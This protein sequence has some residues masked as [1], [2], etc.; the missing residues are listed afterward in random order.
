MMDDEG[1]QCGGIRF[2]HL[3]VGHRGY[4]FGGISYRQHSVSN[5]LQKCQHPYADKGSTTF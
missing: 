3:Q 5:L 2:V 1:I 4:K